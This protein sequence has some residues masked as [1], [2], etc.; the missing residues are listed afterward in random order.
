MRKKRKTYCINFGLIKPNVDVG[1][2]EGVVDGNSLL[3]IDHQHFREQV[4]G[5]GGCKSVSLR[6]CQTKK[7]HAATKKQHKNIQTKKK[8]KKQKK[9]KRKQKGKQEKCFTFASAMGTFVGL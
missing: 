5:L 8:Q 4:T 3:R 2:L 9:Q 1:M 6:I 7:P